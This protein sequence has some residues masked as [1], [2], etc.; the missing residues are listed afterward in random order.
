MPD[1]RGFGASDKPQ[2]V[3]DYDIE[4]SLADL[5][6]LADALGIERFALVGHDWGGAIAWA[7]RDLAA[8]RASSGWRSSTRRTR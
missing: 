8:I 5:F 4:T 2:D 1:Q 7:G 6:A 3:A